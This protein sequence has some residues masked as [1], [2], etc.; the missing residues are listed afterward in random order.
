MKESEEKL[1]KPKRDSINLMVTP[2]FK[3]R[4]KRAAKNEGRLAGNWVRWIV[5]KELDRL[6]GEKNHVE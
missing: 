6:E 1:Q 4:V 5:E 3:R 2:E